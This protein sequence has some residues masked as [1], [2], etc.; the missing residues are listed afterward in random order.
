VTADAVKPK[1]NTLPRLLVGM[2]FHTSRR[3]SGPSSIAFSPEGSSLAFVSPRDGPAVVCE[4]QVSGG[5]VQTLFAIEG[6]AVHGISWARTGE[7]YCGA[8]P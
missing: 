5:E 7:L 3:F 4:V 1:P 6:A 2:M 8:H